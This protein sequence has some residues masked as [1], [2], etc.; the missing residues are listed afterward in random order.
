LVPFSSSDFELARHLPAGRHRAGDRH[1]K[2][3]DYRDNLR[4]AVRDGED[5]AMLPR[6][7]PTAWERLLDESSALTR[8]GR[9]T[10]SRPE[11]RAYA[12]PQIIDYGAV[13]ALGEGGPENDEEEEED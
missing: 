5:A 10:Y 2:F 4:L 13:R 7:V 1:L 9:L 6:T 8:D 11:I 3:H 12:P